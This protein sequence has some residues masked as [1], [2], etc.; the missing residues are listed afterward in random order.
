[1]VAA[2][3]HEKKEFIN[4]KKKMSDFG[5]QA[6]KYQRRL[7]ELVDEDTAAFHNLMSAN[8]LPSK[9]SLD[10]INKAKKLFLANK[11]AT[12][13]PLETAKLSLEII[14]MSIEIIKHGNPNSVTDGHVAA[15]VG[16]AGARGGC[17]NVLINLSSFE[18]IEDYDSKIVE[19]V[20][21]ILKESVQLHRK[22]FS[23]TKKIMSHNI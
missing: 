8:K 10:K 5:E 18:K 19:K 4:K 11:L 21:N 17:M 16:L 6:Q 7:M 3:T 13:T 9:T 22:A 1:M 2:L 20:D 15:E 14:R 23:L 12:D